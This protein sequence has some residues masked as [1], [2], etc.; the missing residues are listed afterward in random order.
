MNSK[1]SEGYQN[2]VE[3]MENELTQL[4]GISDCARSIGLDP[5]LPGVQRIR[6]GYDLYDLS[7]GIGGKPS[8][9]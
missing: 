6:P 2:Y 5:S 4:Y 7:A 3:T 1:M 9:G 8:P